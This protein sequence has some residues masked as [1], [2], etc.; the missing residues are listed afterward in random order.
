MDYVT[1]RRE[2]RQIETRILSNIVKID[3]VGP[4]VAACDRDSSA[5]SGDEEC[6]VVVGYRQIEVFADGLAVRVGRGHRNWGVAYI[7]DG[8]GTRD[9]AG[10][11]INAEAGWHRGRESQRIASRRSGE[12][13]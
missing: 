12:V 11:G 7:A 9:D 4:V 3:S 5:V 13:A 2:F 6:I 8:R 10:V 1:V